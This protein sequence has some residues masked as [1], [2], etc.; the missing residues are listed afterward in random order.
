MIDGRAGW[1]AGVRPLALAAA[2]GVLLAAGAPRR[3]DAQ[4]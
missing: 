4:G 3:T 1:S 2:L